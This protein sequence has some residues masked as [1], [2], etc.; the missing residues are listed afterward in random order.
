MRSP[1]HFDFLQVGSHVG[2]TPNDPIFAHVTNKTRG[3]LVEPIPWIFEQLR[4]NYAGRSAGLV[5]INKAVSSAPGTLR[6]YAPSQANDWAHLPVW[7]SQLSSVRQNHAKDHGLLLTTELVE[8]E[9]TTIAQI[10]VQHGVRELGLLHTDTEGH[11]AEILMSLDFRSFR[12]RR[13]LFES[14]HTD[15]TCR[16]S[17]E[18]QRALERLAMNGYRVTREDSE[19]TLVE[20]GDT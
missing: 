7:A 6:L 14:K 3:I 5:F 18:Y 4:S 13:I 2:N 15:G 16:R 9:A 17:H 1:G 10:C 11:D 8:A 12:P 19:D 20:L